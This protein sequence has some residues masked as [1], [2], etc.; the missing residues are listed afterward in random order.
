LIET[1]YQFI[2]VSGSVK[3]FMRGIKAEVAALGIKT[4]RKVFEYSNE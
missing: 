1:G 2:N 3:L 4:E